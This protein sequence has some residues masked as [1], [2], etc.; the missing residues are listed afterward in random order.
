MESGL[1]FGRQNFQARLHRQLMNYGINVP[2][3]TSALRGT[4]KAYSDKRQYVRKLS[5]SRE[6][7]AFPLIHN[8]KVTGEHFESA[9]AIRGHYFQQDLIVAQSIYARNPQR[10][11]DVGSSIAGFVSHV[12]S[13]RTIEVLDIRPLDFHVPGI[14]FRQADIMNLDLEEVVQADSVSCLHA[15]EHFGLGRYGDDIDPDGWRKGY[16]G[17]LRLL[18]SQGTLYLSVPTG[19]RQRLEFNAHRVFSV[20][21]LR[22][23]L[24]QDL[25][26]IDLSFIHDDGKLLM[27][28]DPYG[29]EAERSFGAEYGC[30]IWTA[31]KR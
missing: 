4:P 15:L 6:G 27:N 19:E 18:K 8:W 14:F 31:I 26:I 21:Y 16:E 12:A 7:A 22:N 9:G 25:E 10:H 5:Y 28:L 23:V 1:G 3:M 11:I 13:F 2:R 17:L 24:E 20:P 30:S 29:S